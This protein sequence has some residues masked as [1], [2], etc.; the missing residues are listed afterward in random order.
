MSSALEV[1]GLGKTYEKLE[2]VADLSFHVAPGEVL[3]LVG[4]NG[5]GKT[6]TLRCLAGII[7][8]TRGTVRI[9]GH[10]LAVEPVPAKRELAFLPDE[11]RLFEYLTV[12]EH[13]NLVARLFGV[14]DWEP[15]GEHLLSELELSGKQ[16]ALPGEL[17]R[18]MKQKL[19][20][21]CGFLHDPK[22]ILLDEPLTGLDP[23]GIRKMKE[24]LKRRAEKGAALV[25]SSHLLPLVEELCDRILIIAKGR[26]VALGT[27]EEIRARIGGSAGS[28]EDLFIEITSRPE[29]AAS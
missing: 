3:G 4:P 7:P 10:D 19:A 5:A 15:R 28:L 27:I 25:L 26:V 14:A 1:E 23:L 9:C 20:I 13:L 17:S 29:T 6:S 24:S 18:G 21:A 2:A 11:P 8:P 22:V 12:R 16:G